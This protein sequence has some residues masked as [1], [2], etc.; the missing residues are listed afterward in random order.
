MANQDELER[1]IGELLKQLE[2]ESPDGK[3]GVVRGFIHQAVHHAVGGGVEFCAL[4]SYLGEMV[5]HAHK[6]M[7]TDNPKAPQHKDFV[8]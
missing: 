6:L 8:H 3:W 7:H 2:R 1:K 4:A 5:G